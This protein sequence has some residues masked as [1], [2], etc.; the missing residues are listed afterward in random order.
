MRILEGVVG[1]IFTL[2][3]PKDV[4]RHPL[5]RRIVEAYEADDAGMHLIRLLRAIR[6]RR[7][8]IRMLVCP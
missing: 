8:V 7:S 2:V 1:I 5:V 6:G 3:S 4:V